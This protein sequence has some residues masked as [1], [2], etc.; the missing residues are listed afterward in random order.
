[1]LTDAVLRNLTNLKLTNIVLFTFPEVFAKAHVELGSAI[2]GP[3]KTFSDD[4]VGFPG[5]VT[6]KVF[7][8]LIGG[9]LIQTTPF[10]APCYSD[11]G[12]ENAA[13][14]AEIASHWYNDSYIQ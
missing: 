5:I 2:N 8:L 14:C 1:M 6:N 9:N 10:A 12:N 7:D 11:F 13:E 4:F 3:C